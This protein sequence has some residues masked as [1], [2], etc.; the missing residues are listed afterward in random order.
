MSRNTVS[1]VPVDDIFAVQVLKHQS[2][3]SAIETRDMK[4]GIRIQG[5]M[6]W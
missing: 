2:N 5:Y 1:S 6:A 3:L 4:K